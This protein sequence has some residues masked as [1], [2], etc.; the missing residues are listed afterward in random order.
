M[1][2]TDFATGGY[3]YLPGG[4]FPFSNGVRA[5]PGYFLTR[6]RLRQRPSLDDGLAMAAAWLRSVNRPPA[7][8][9]LCE[10]RSPAALPRSG[11]A[12]A[13]EIYTALL[14]KYGFGAPGSFPV[15]RS[16]VAPR[17]DAPTQSSL[18]AFSY[19]SPVTSATEPGGRDFIISGKAELSESPPRIIAEG[20]VTARGLRAKAE[21]VIEDLRLRTA[22]LGARW[23]DITGC[24]L[25]TVHS[26][27]SV[28]DLLADPVLCAAGISYIPAFPPV[29]LLEFEV[30]VRGVSVELTL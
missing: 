29:Q 3:A 17:I 15:G 18:H 25:Y 10:L 9:A 13:N 12:G 14:A 1:Q 21:Y 7:A 20:D 6:V 27:D 19:A 8:L 26:L 5:L 24:Q 23:S 30:D 16:N 22:A 28:L 4:A 2:S 11:F